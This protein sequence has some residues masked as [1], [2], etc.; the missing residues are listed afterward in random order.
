MLKTGIMSTAYFGIEDYESGIK[1]MKAH[2]YDCMDYQGI[3]SCNSVFF[4]YGDNAFKNYFKSFGECAQENGVEIFQ[5][6]GLW[7][8]NA[9]GDLD[10]ADIDEELYI[11]QLLAAEYMGCKRFVM[12]PCM[13][14]GWGE[15]EIKERAFIE[16]VKTINK[17]LPYAKKAGVIICVE[18]MPFKKGHSFS[19]IG[20]LKKLIRTINDEN[21]KACFD[22]GHG[23]CTQEDIY[24]CITTLGEDLETLHVHD[25]IACQDR[26]LIPFQGVI[27]WGKFIKGLKEIEYKGCISLETEI[28]NRMPLEIREKMQVALA[29]LARWFVLLIEGE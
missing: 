2:G 20:E 8:R 24:D 10:K 5:M 3:A 21:V 7:P 15:E 28:S 16:T 22:T 18:N 19:D 17:L 26:H 9:D 23:N 1:K 12:H 11:K 29:D 13:P 25:D 27:D 6:H 4:K 14:Y